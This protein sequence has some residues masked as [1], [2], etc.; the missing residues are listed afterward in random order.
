MLQPKFLTLIII[1]TGVV[2]CNKNE[3][4]PIVY[5]STLSASDPS[6]YAGSGNG[7]TCG[8]NQGKY[9]VS[10]TSPGAYGYALVPINGI[11]FQYSVSVD[12]STQL[13]DASKA[14]YCGLFFNFVDL[15]NYMGFIV[16]PN[17]KFAI[18]NSAS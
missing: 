11:N 18:F 16:A 10:L 17:G 1:L 4:N 12:A 15:N 7:Y 9:E 14:G 3:E 2:S 5:Q 6:W 8:F 13:S